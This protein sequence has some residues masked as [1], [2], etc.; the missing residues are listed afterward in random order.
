MNRAAVST[1]KNSNKL[2]LL[3]TKPPSILSVKDGIRRSLETAIIAC[4]QGGRLPLSDLEPVMVYSLYY[5]PICLSL[6]IP[7][8]QPKIGIPDYWSPRQFHITIHTS[9]KSRMALCLEE[10]SST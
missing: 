6:P 8:V 9:S 2:A 7:K 3:L 1:P 4:A 5:Q 10:V